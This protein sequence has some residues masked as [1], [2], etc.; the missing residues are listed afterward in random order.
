MAWVICFRILLNEK[1]HLDVSQVA[2]VQYT[3]VSGNR[4]GAHLGGLTLLYMLH[5]VFAVIKCQLDPYGLS[6]LF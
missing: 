5:V 3:V 2:I 6:C 1:T 4:A